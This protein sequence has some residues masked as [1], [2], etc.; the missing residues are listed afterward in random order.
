M[1]QS[2]A[3]PTDCSGFNKSFTLPPGQLVD[4]EF[5]LDDTFHS[6]TVAKTSSCKYTNGTST[7]GNCD[8]ACEVTTPVSPFENAGFGSLSSF[9]HALG[10]SID[11]AHATATAVGDGAKCGGAGGGAVKACFACLCNVNVTVSKS[12]IDIS[13]SSDGFID[14]KD[15][16]DNNCPAQTQPPPGADGCDPTAST[17]LNVVQDMPTNCDPIVLD[18]KGDGFD[19][20]NAA[21]GVFFD[22]RGTGHPFMIPWT[23]GADTAF[24]VLDRNANG[25]IDDGTELFSNVSPQPR[26][27]SPNGFK[28]LAQ[29]DLPENGGNGDGIIDSRDA[30]FQSLRLWVDVNHDGISQIEELHTLP[31]LGVLSI[32]LDFQRT[33]RK[34]QYGN[35]FL[36]RARV[37]PGQG[38]GVGRQA[39][40]VFFVTK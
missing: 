36:F 32:S 33:S 25:R 31:G 38:A 39:Y 30:I 1:V 27:T 40:D 11:N 35:I 9:C 15:G 12:G 18:L 26:S 21:G 17:D 8:T 37:N 22:I 5:H 34:D 7:S 23:T 28:A 10:T 14:F 20:T 16:V 4:N 2:G 24:L 6:I 19:L 3:P 29:Y 13:I